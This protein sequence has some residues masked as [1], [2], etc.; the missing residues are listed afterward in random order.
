MS[1]AG[2]V[3]V[4]LCLMFLAFAMT[5]DAI[6]GII[7]QVIAEYHLSMKAAG[8]LHYVLMASI[9]LG[10]LLLG[11]LA[12]RLGRKWTLILGLALRIGPRHQHFQDRR[13]CTRWRCFDFC[14]R[15]Y[16]ADEHR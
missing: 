7:P 2:H 11:F 6:G 14:Q 10:A 15:S 13:T 8:A 3:R 16:E 9:G 1:S 4:L 12:D 5:S